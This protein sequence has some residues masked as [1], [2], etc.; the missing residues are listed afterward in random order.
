MRRGP[1]TDAWIWTEQ[2]PS[3]VRGIGAPFALLSLF[4]GTGLARLAVE[5][6][7]RLRNGWQLV[8]AAYAEIEPDLANAVGRAWSARAHRRGGGVAYRHIAR[9][10]WDL[11]RQRGGAGSTPLQDFARGLPFGCCV[12]IVA[13][14]PC[15]NLTFGGRHQG[16][17]GLCGEASVLFFA[18]PT[19]AW[20]LAEM[21]PDVT[22]HVILENAASMTPL[23]RTAILRALGG[24]VENLHLRTLDAANWTAFPRRRLFLCTVPTNEED[25]GE[26]ACVHLTAG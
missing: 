4:D 12:I 19:V 15:Q 14:S 24:L 11:F 18:V 3:V 23:H 7:L 21:R 22:V 10:V 5:E 2:P 9:D 17:Q 26:P 13:G 6:L 16:R 8:D 25:R 1:R 20:A